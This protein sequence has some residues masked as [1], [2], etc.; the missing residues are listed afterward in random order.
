MFPLQVIITGQFI[1]RL[2]GVRQLVG[3]L[4]FY[5][6]GDKSPHSKEALTFLLTMKLNRHIVPELT[7]KALAVLRAWPNFSTSLTSLLTKILLLSQ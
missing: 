2:L 4:V 7:E 1:T 6:S 3:S 5:Q